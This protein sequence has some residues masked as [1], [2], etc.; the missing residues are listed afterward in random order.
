MFSKILLVPESDSMEQPSIRR[1]S[2]LAGDKTEV[3]VFEPVHEPHLDGY[4][5]NASIYEPL[6]GYMIKEKEAALTEL[7]QT[8]KSQGI[9]CTAKTR[10][11][12]PL[13]QAIVREAL[14]FNAALVIVTPARDR[15]G[16][17]LSSSDW[18]LVADCPAPVL[19]VKSDGKTP[20]RNI[21]A[22]VDP[23]HAHAKPHDLDDAIISCAKSVQAPTKAD[24]SLLHCFL[25]LAHF[26]FGEFDRTPIRDAEL[27]LEKSRQQALNALA[28]NAGLPSNFAR[29]A[30]GNPQTVLESMAD[31][32]ETD[33]IVMGGLSRGM[34]SDLLIGST[35]DKVLRHVD[36]DV[37]IVKPPNLKIGVSVSV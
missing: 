12:H 27:S 6:R 32:G 30:E 34:I 14:E 1:L 25:P 26:E 4:F 15:R 2:M 24:L 35:A 21:V 9:Q 36:C 19:I 20:Y 7:A 23:V 17:L 16:G 5:G 11:D 29:L 8:I 3:E 33:L 22:A 37:L 18:R 13:D 10:W 31:S 28:T